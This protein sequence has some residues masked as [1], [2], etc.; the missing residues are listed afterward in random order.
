MATETAT[1]IGGVNGHDSH[2]SGSV[3]MS[4]ALEANDMEHVPTIL[5]GI[6]EAGQQLSV[7]NSATRL[8]LLE[9]ARDLVR[10]LETPRETM[11]KHCWAETNVMTALSVCKSRGIFDLLAEHGGSPKLAKDLAVRSGVDPPLLCQ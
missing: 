1:P 2:N 3:A 4:I 11:I 5:K 10:A 7:D 8:K 9:R 6:E